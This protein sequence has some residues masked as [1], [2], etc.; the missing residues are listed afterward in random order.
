[1][2]ITTDHDKGQGTRELDMTVETPLSFESP[3]SSS[4]TRARYDP[5]TRQLFVDLR[6]AAVSYRYT[7]VDMPLWVEFEQSTSKGKFFAERIR[8]LYVGIKV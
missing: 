8:P 5:E 3:E 1:M 7:A 4:I 6:K 2:D